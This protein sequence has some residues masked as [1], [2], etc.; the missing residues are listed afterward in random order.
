M[1]D[2]SAAAPEMNH[3]AA[4]VMV[5]QA[6]SEELRGQQ[7]EHGG[8]LVSD[9]AGRWLA[10]DGWNHGPAVMHGRAASSL[11]VGRGA[12]GEPCHASLMP[13]WLAQIY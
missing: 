12:P 5:L 3:A 7:Q 10:S 11:H 13:L 4:A 6:Y 8:D 1:L 9:M 2:R